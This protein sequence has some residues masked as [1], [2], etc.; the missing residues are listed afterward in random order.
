M[1]K[2]LQ[3]LYM[4]LLVNARNNLVFHWKDGTFARW[5]E[6]YSDPVEFPGAG[7]TEIRSRITEGI[8]TSG[9]L[10]GVFQRAIHAFLTAPRYQNAGSSA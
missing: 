6:R 1:S 2:K 4:R 8:E 3:G 5:V 7:D 9:L 10:V